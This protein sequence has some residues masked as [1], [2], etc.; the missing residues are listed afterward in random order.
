[1]DCIQAHV[2]VYSDFI[3]QGGTWYD[4]SV[5]D[6]KVTG[7]ELAGIIAVE[8]CGESDEIA[9][10]INDIGGIQTEVY[11]QIEG[12]EKIVIS[13]ADGTAEAEQVAVGD[14][15]ISIRRFRAA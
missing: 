8:L 4:S 5:R 14:D 9:I 2:L 3:Q 13:R 11:C 6:E 12:L 10:Y 15:G 1:M 7:G